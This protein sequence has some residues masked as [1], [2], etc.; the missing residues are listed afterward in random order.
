MSFACNFRRVKHGA[1][2]HKERPPQLPQR[3]KRARTKGLNPKARIAESGRRGA[4][5]SARFRRDR[6]EPIV[7]KKSNGVGA[8]FIGAPLAKGYRRTV[9]IERVLATKRSEQQSDIAHGS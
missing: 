3:L 5:G 4:D 1:A 7:L 9:G 2:L 6:H 8:Q